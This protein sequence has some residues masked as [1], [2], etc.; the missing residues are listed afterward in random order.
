MKP[1]VKTSEFWLT[2]A[3]QVVAAVLIALGHAELGAALVAVSGGTYNVSRGA[4]KK[5]KA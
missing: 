1:G 2:A 4:A 5:A 3:A